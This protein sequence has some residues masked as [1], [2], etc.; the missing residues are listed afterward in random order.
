MEKID[1]TFGGTLGLDMSTLRN[2]YQWALEIYDLRETVK[3]KPHPIQPETLA[4][5][6]PRDITDIGKRNRMDREDIFTIREFKKW[7]ATVFQIEGINEFNIRMVLR[8][9]KV[10]DEALGAA[11]EHRRDEVELKRETLVFYLK[12]EFN[13]PPDELDEALSDPYKY[14]KRKSV[15]LEAFNSYW[16]DPNRYARR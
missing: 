7:R 4:G 5:I 8:A 12:N 1:L 14:A 10:F 13:I 15:D 16:R 11:P 9:V 2:R 6:I 3:R